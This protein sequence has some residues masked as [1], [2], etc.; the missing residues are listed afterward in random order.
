VPEPVEPPKPVALVRLQ[1]DG[2]F[3]G[4]YCGDLLEGM[5][6]V[7]IVADARPE[8]RAVPVLRPLWCR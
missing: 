7:N 5:G 1:A 6:P 4:D 8:E 2:H 3:R